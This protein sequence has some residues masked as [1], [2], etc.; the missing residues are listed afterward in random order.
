M[1][2][3][4]LLVVG[5]PPDDRRLRFLLRRRPVPRAAARKVLPAARGQRRHRLWDGIQLCRKTRKC[6]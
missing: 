6:N 1:R 4:D 5:E 3:E 2:G